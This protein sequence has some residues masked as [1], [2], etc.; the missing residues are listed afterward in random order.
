MKNLNSLYIKMI[1]YYKNDPKRIQH[2]CKVHSFAKLIAEMENMSAKDLEILETAALVH[3]I[4]IKISEQ[5][6]GNCSGKNQEKEGPAE[7]VRLL[8]ELD[9][10]EDVIE[11]VSYLVGHHHTYNNIDG[12]DYQILV[13]SDFIVNMYE[14]QESLSTCEK[15]YDR[16]FKT[17]SGRKIFKEMF[18]L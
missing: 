8:K 4:G 12:L 16:I 17:D 15:V 7:A 10:P 2:F 11:R 13:E 18:G 1:E 14:D 5:K 9:Y 6:Y 3:D